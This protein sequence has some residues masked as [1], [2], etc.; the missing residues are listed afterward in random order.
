MEL[1]GL[2]IPFRINPTTGGFS[3]QK[4]SAEK[5]KEN[6]IHIL[7]TGD[8]ERPM[9]RE[10]GSGLKQLLHD[11]NND[12]LRAILRHQIGKAITKWEPRVVL[13]EIGVTGEGANLFANLQFSIRGYTG[14]Q[15]LSVPI[16]LGSV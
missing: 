12:A 1:H 11:P 5:L 14:A 2:S 7:L 6:L 13:Q 8:G 4:N 15:T 10:Y 3:W 9:R 16:E